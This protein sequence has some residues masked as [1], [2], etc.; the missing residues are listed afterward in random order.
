MR[1]LEELLES[2]LNRINRLEGK[3]DLSR[4]AYN[5]L[6][7]KNDEELDGYDDLRRLKLATF[8]HFLTKWEYVNNEKATGE[9]IEF[10]NTFPL[11]L[12]S[13]FHAEIEK[14]KTLLD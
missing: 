8:N 6:K 9:I 3:E 5:D 7:T 4:K 11:T 13:Y 1:L 14:N 12:R 10:K 2:V